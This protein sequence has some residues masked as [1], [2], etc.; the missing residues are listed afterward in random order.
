MIVALDLLSGLAEG[1][2]HHIEALASSSNLLKLLYQCMQVG[3]V[4]F[5]I[6]IRAIMLKNLPS[7][8][9]EQNL[10]FEPMD[11]ILVHSTPLY[12]M[13]LCSLCLI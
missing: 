3:Q 11:F 13:L 7:N 8:S 2:E 4:F 1:V 5:C 6:V 9:L 10:N 12:I